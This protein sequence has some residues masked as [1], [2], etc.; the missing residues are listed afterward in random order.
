MLGKQMP[1]LGVE[2]LLDKSLPGAFLLRTYGAEKRIRLDDTA[3]HAQKN[4]RSF[5]MTH[6]K[7]LSTESLGSRPCSRGCSAA[8]WGT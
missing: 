3:E 8:G 1:G 6:G 2:Q 7:L 4:V 5:I